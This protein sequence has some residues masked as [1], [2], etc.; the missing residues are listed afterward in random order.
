[1]LGV[2][3]RV[4]FLGLETSFV[5]FEFTIYFYLIEETGEGREVLGG[6]FLSGWF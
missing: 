1:M 5:V 2:G 4:S 3:F 6:V